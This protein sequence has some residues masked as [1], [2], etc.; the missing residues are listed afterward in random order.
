MKKKKKNVKHSWKG[1]TRR[2][3]NPPDI[4]KP[5]RQKKLPAEKRKRRITAESN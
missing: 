4:N 5:S 2:Y 3:N 1:R